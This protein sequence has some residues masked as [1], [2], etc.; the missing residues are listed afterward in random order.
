MEKLQ[1]L[2][3]QCLGQ[4]F[5][6]MIISNPRKSD[7]ARKIDVRPYDERGTIRFSLQNTGTT[8]CFTRIGQRRRPWNKFSGCLRLLTDR[9]NFA[10]HKSSIQFL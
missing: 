10:R 2:L 6:H 7:A 3:E 9:W 8:R 1:E 5:V 4:N